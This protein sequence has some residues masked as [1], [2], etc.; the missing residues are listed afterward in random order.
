MA[1][2]D[3]TTKDEV[4]AYAGVDFSLGIGPSDAQLATMI[5]NASRLVD[6]FAK[7]TVAHDSL[8]THTDYFDVYR[9][10]EHIVIANRPI[11]AITSIVELDSNG[12]ETAWVESRNR[13]NT[14]SR[15]FWLEDNNAGIVRFMSPF[16]ADVKQFIKVVYTAG[17]TTPTPEAK[18]ATILL[19][20]RQA[21]R[22]AMNDENCTDRIKEFWQRLINDTAKELDDALNLVKG[23]A[24]TTA[25]TYGLGGGY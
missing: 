4:E 23:G 20:V 9:G 8:P 12:N 1:A 6:V 18:M 14:T 16:S 22:A 10:M 24:E 2:T 25:A 13:S 7:R 21:G 15:T 5:T 19:V 17:R 11:G 3:Y